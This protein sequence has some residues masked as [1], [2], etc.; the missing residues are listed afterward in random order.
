MNGSGSK[1]SVIIGTQLRQAREMLQF[2]LEEVAQ[3]L[4]VNLQDIVSWEREQSKPTLKQLEALAEL[5][6][7]EI[8]YFL[9]ETPVPPEKIEFRGKPRVSLR[10]LSKDAK[11]VLARFDEL[12]RTA[13]EFEN[14]LKKRREV[15][16]P[17][18]N[19]SD[20][21]QIVAQNLRFQFGA[22][23][24]PLPDLRDR[25]ENM[26]VRI[27]ELP[28]PDDAFSGFSWLHS[29]YGPCIL[30]NAN[31]LK[32]RRNFTLAHELAHLVYRHESTVCYIP[33]K[34]GEIHRGIEYKANQFA[35]ELLLP[36]SS[37]EK[38]FS[39]RNLSATPSP[40]ELGQVAY[41]WG[42]SLQ[43]LGYRLE[44]LGLITIGHT[45]TLWEVRP[46]HFRPPKTPAWERQLDKQFVKT[47]FDAYQKGLISSGK[48]A[49]SLGITIRKALEEI[50]KRTGQ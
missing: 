9:R 41:K 48:L 25:L 2:T 18:F 19:E 20:T 34:F 39:K 47:T 45:D 44:K 5:Y 16:L 15:K 23:D 28:V 11:I 38:D 12:C 4:N 33:L 13:F 32:G 8:D 6:G 10:N 37:V 40:Q 24:R 1:K 7:R 29:Q 50:A 30:L 17:H 43:A 21:P 49:H 3:E 27:F 26:G 31:E 42:V 46:P 35:I 36:E 14:L 22:D